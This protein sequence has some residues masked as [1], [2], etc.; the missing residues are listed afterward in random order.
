MIRI[1]DLHGKSRYVNADLIQFI[2]S[3]PD[4]QLVMSDGRR[5]FVREAPEAVVDL[6]VGYKQR[7]NAPL[8]LS[9]KPERIPDSDV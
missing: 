6:V 7:C 9:K 4:T 3:A 8:G 2:D 5:I 1:T